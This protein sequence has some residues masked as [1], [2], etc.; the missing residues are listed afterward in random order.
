MSSM[1]KK[2]VLILCAVIGAL[3]PVSQA[4]LLIDK[5]LLNGGFQQIDSEKPPASF[6][7]T[8]GWINLAGD[9]SV[10]A[11]A[12]DKNGN[13]VGL[14][15]SPLIFAQDLKYEICAGDQF[16]VCFKTKTF[17]DSLE[18]KL[19]M[20]LYYYEDENADVQTGEKKDLFTLSSG[21]EKGKWNFQS[22]CS[23]VL[24]SEQ[25]IGKKLW[26]RFEVDSL[27]ENIKI[28]F[29]NVRIEAV[30][31]PATLGL[32]GVFGG[33]LFWIRRRARR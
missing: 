2:S 11:V 8:P 17:S 7:Q 10:R 32:V 33:M 3:A 4:K 6:E 15:N 19:K 18:A 24:A 20:T 22:D 27:D 14:I 21:G 31:E 23:G 13:K 1:K 30:P 28:R 25:A 12:N 5:D 26:V 29:D 16:D 9:Q